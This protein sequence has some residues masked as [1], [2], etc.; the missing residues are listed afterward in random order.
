MRFTFDGKDYTIEF[1]R[2][3]RE[4]VKTNLAGDDVV[5]KSTKPYTT[6]TLL[7]AD[8]GRPQA[9][10]TYR[11]ATVGCWHKDKFSLETGR[12]RALR[13]MTR[14]LPKA[15]KPVL[16]K[17]YHDRVK[18]TPAPAP[19]GERDGASP[20]SLGSLAEAEDASLQGSS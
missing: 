19:A 10:T 8:L 20:E 7:E 18:K 6:V 12:V 16:W 17:A 1:Q 11:T 4:R 13:S 9:K 14:T 5:T 2:S 15:M 3:F